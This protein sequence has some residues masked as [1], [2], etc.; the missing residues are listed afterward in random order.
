MLTTEYLAIYVLTSTVTGNGLDWK[1]TSMRILSVLLYYIYYIVYYDGEF[2]KMATQ[3]LSRDI[4]SNC[5]VL[6]IYGFL[7][8]LVTLT[9]ALCRL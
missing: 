2:G 8:S 5:V 6:N 7:S 3:M 1:R 9:P 4:Y